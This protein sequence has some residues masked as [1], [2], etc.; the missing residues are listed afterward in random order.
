MGFPLTGSIARLIGKHKYL[1]NHWANVYSVGNAGVSA[2]AAIKVQR[3]RSKSSSEMD[4]L[5]NGSHLHLVIPPIDGPW[6]AG[7]ER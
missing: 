4:G 2:I 5:L 1:H 3:G 6:S 7:D